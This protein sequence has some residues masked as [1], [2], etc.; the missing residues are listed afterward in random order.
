ME[1][2]LL[3]TKVWQYLETHLGMDVS[4]FAL[5]K[6]PFENLSSA[7]LAKQLKG[8]QVLKE[9]VPLWFE[10]K[11]VLCPMGLNLE[12]CSSQATALYKVGLIDEKYPKK[13]GIDLTCGLGVDA[14]FFS[15]IFEKFTLVE[16]NEE[17]LTLVKENFTNLK[18]ENVDFVLSNA[19][20]FLSNN[21]KS[22]DFIYLDPDR[23]NKAN[24]KRI[25]PEDL[26]PNLHLIVDVLLERSPLVMVKFSPMMD[27]FQLIDSFFCSEI[28]VVAVKN[29]V[30]ELVLLFDKNKENKNPK[31]V[32]VNLESTHKTFEFSLKNEQELAISY[33]S[34][35]KYL[36][37]PNAAILKAGSFK[38]ITKEYEVFKIDTN[39]HLY[40]SIELLED[41]PGKGYE[42]LE[43]VEN[44]KSIAKQ[45]FQLVVRNY[46]LN[47]H[48]IKAK[49]KL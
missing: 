7:Q 38:S 37:L 44:L 14:F 36:Y 1:N 2:P 47:I 10:S 46:P 19:E 18:V 30:K 5:L 42:I 48:K 33:H 11:K 41:F 25:L 49:Y 4:A 17:L 12:Q 9:K 21:P 28:H 31:I 16:Q 39:S 20:N 8:L 6:S 34:V 29:Q 32:A 24:Q 3:E 43:K 13:N 27:L 35:Q 45:S 26:S 40:T 23:R 22:F 15:R